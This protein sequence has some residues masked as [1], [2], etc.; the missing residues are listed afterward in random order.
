MPPRCDESINYDDVWLYLFSTYFHYRNV[1]VFRR[2]MGLE[3]TEVEY[4]FKKYFQDKHYY[5]QQQHLLWALYFLRRY[6][7]EESAAIKF[8]TS[9]KTFR[10]RVW[11]ILHHLY[12]NM[13]E[14]S[15]AD[16]L[17]QP[18]P[19]GIFNGCL[20]ALDATECKIDRPGIYVIQHH[21]YSGKFL[22]YFINFLG[23]KKTHTIKYEIGVNLTNG[24]IIWHFGGLPGRV[25]DINITAIGELVSQLASDEYI[26][27]D[28]GKFN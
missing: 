10:L 26:L 4:V 14:V 8:H 9:V 21:F 22:L 12:R 28:T 2:F 27:A 11:Q 15:F 23:K 13:N 20:F 7:T 18:M 25:H 3:P 5:I 17:K 24:L 16:R 19:N 6:E 1:H